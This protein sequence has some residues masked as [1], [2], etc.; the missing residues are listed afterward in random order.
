MVDLPFPRSRKPVTVYL[1]VKPASAKEKWHIQTRQSGATEY[2]GAVRPKEAGVW[3]WLAFPPRTAGEVGD[4]FDVCCLGDKTVA[5][6]AFLDHVVLSTKE[7]LTGAELAAAQP[8]CSRRPLAL[9]ARAA[10]APTLDGRGDDPCWRNAVACTGFLDMTGLKAAE[11]D[12]TV[13]LCHDDA[14]LYLLFVCQEPM[15]SVARQQRSKFLAKVTQ[16]DGDVYADDSVAVLL[17]PSD[18]GKQVYGFF[19]NALGT[20][21]DARCPGPDL[22]AM[23]DVEWRSSA[24]A[25]GDMGDGVWTLEMAIPFADLGGVPKPGDV[26]QACLGRLAKARKET[27][28]WNPSNKGFHDPYQLG[29]L[30]F[31]GATPGVAL[32]MPASLQPGRNRLA[33]TLSPLPGKPTG[34][35]LHSSVGSVKP[36]PKSRLRDHTY[37]FADVSDG[38]VDVSQILNLRQ[39]GDLLVEYAVLDAATLRPLYLTPLLPRVVKSSVAQVKLSCDGPYEL[40]LGDEVI[41]RGAQAKGEAI[42]VPLRKGANVFALKLDKGTAAIAVEAS[43]S[44]FTAE[45]WRISAADTKDAT[46]AALDDVSWPIAKTVGEHPLLGPVVGESGRAVVLR[47]TLLWEKTRVWPTPQPAYYLARGPAQHFTVIVDGLPGK[48]LEGWTTTIAAP[49][50]FEVLGSSGF[51]GNN[52]DQP[53]FAC[54]PLGSRQI[55]GRRMRVVK[56]TADKPVLSG[57]HYI[58]SLFE[59]FVR[60][61]EEAG[62]PQST[63]AEL[64]YWGEANGGSVTEPPQ[65]LQVRLLPKLAGRQPRHLTLQLWGGWFGNMD[66]LA[67]R[68]E[69]L[70]CAR[71]AGFNDIVDYDRWT[72][73]TGRKYGLPLTHAINFRPWNMNLTAYLKE[74]P[75][76][77]LITRKTQPDDSHLC[78]TRLLGESWP[79]VESEL[80]KCLDKSRPGAVDIDY[81]YGPLKS[82]GP[83]HS[84]YCP[85]CLTAFRE[86]AEL[87]PDVVL[88][89]QIVK[90]K[91]AAQW[92]DFMARRVAQ[93]FAKFKDAVHRLA[94]GTLFSVYSGYQTPANP[95]MYGVDWRYIGDLQA[96]DRAAAGYGEPE[97]DIYR[98]VEAL[99]GI[100]LLPGLLAV[101]YDTTVTT[102]RTPITKARILRHLLASTGAGVMVYNRCSLDGRT[103]Y[104]MAEISR[105]AATFEQV[106]LKG[107]PAPLAGFDVTQAQT[108]SDGRTT[109]ICVMN[110]G[111]KSAEYAI[112]LPT[113]TGPGEEF[114]SGREVAAGEK[115]MCALEP[116]DAAAYVLRR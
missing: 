98:T 94:P 36:G 93:M 13:R 64:L 115:V 25:R 15:L 100:P 53:T 70:R 18:T 105:L 58:M 95:E 23:R 8:W 99:K 7:N 106:F 9:V 5:S 6:S 40:T 57:R 104:A 54:T 37:T 2:V 72:S 3:Q 69:I 92:I 1:R 83:P 30:V 62:E 116:G 109:L 39:E 97:A 67:M 86:Y 73:D 19:A 87:A 46:S 103:W 77:R 49:P 88:D 76:E 28:S 60:Y 96:C 16:R 48:R 26:W 81:E 74:H 41:S 66:D 79:A 4:R 111:S 12:T 42:R 114:Y 52:T 89:P 113:D 38:D 55:S 108:I 90:E 17:D 44:R 29:T 24:R 31:G 84:C 56:V 35:Y 45:S 32:T 107:Q 59:V 34:V 11:A 68:E 80:K 102:P 91:V 51:Y 101:P 65:R 20:I 50:A 112:R 82:D 27:T 85:R 110:Q 61:R 33:A 78:M 43:G 47:R 10:R 21:V 63:E 14:N 22:W 71:A 75:D